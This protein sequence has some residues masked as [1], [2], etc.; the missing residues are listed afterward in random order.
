MLHHVRAEEI[1]VAQVVH[2]PVERSEHHK[3]A[4]EEIYLLLQRWLPPE[5]MRSPQVKRGERGY[6]DGGAGMNRPP[7]PIDRGNGMEQRQKQHATS[8]LD[9]QLSE[10]E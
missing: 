1:P 10:E 5:M 3:E 9:D 6:A 7:P 4:G 2:R 8:E